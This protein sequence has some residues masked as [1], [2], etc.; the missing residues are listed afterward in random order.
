[1]ETNLINTWLILYSLKKSRH[2]SP[3]KSFRMHIWTLTKSFTFL[4]I[5]LH[6]PACTGLTPEGIIRA[7]NTL[8]HHQNNLKSLQINGIYNIKKEHV[9]T[10]FSH[11]KMNPLQQKLPPI[12]YHHYRSSS[13]RSTESDRIIDVG[14][15]PQCNEVRMVFDCPRETCRQMRGQLFEICRGCNFCIPRCEECGGCVCAE[16]L[17]EAACPDI[18][19][20][21]CWLN[22][23]KC[24]YCNKPYCKQH[25]N[26]QFSSPGCT[27]FICE[28]CHMTALVDSWCCR[29]MYRML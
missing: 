29:I 22:L 15:C 14:I 20:S 8:S 17:E 9:E 24:N 12:L 4:L 16:E 27:G 10:I 23:P 28:A 6:L 7:V 25:S 5:Q 11:L 3:S 21:N 18:L 26:Q 19:C 13:S 1:M 2:N